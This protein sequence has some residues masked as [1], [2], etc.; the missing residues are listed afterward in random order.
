MHINPEVSPSRISSD[1]LDDSFLL[2]SRDW[3][4]EDQSIKQAN[5]RALFWKNREIP[6]WRNLG[7]QLT[8]N[9]PRVRSVSHENSALMF[10]I[11][12]QSMGVELKRTEAVK[13]LLSG[14]WILKMSF[15]TCSLIPPSSVEPPDWSRH[16]LLQLPYCPGH[17]ELFHQACARYIY[18]N[19]ING[20]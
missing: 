18:L 11:L 16:G 4:C 10:T 2:N 6:F 3:K 8:S 1:S 13:K 12:T 20:N 17:T 5:R 14:V 19:R 15:G 7:W 9:F